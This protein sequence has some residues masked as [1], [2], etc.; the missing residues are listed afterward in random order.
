MR[1]APDVQF[2]LDDGR[3]NGFPPGQQRAFVLAKV[4]EQNPVMIVGS[5]CSEL[6]SA[7]KMIPVAT[8]EA[9]LER[10]AANLGP[11]CRVLVVPH[12]LQTLPVFQKPT[13]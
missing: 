11:D 13:G 6:V 9:A 7:C 3:R 4:L 2:I 8:M 12:A 10:A 1:A 5:E